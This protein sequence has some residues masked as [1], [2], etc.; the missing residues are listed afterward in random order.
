[1]TPPVYTWRSAIVPRSQVVTAG[2]T[3][4]QG[5]L[6]LGGAAGVNPE[7][8]GWAELTLDF[9]PLATEAANVAFSW[10]MSRIRNGNIMRIRL[11]PSVQLVPEA[12]LT[13]PDTGV[14]WANG[15]PWA[16]DANW[17]AEPWVPLT[18]SA[19]RGS[20][21]VTAD[22]SPLGQVLE[23]GHV[24]GFAADG[25]DFTHVVMDVSYDGD[26]IA[27]V[28]VSPPLRRDFL[29]DAEMK[30][31]PAFTGTCINAAEVAATFN[32][33]VWAQPGQMRFVEAL[34]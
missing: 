25:Y 30:L 24:V 21:T 13:V 11:W 32:S 15:M 20:E 17:R 29:P 18:M 34:V 16:N 28:T 33:G 22:F 27:T 4:Y 6:L 7:P 5:G 19:A 26:D 1:M 9:G 12:S 14:T 8:G 2:G 31:R 10:T 3:A 23:I